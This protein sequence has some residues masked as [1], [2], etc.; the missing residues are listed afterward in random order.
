MKYGFYL[1]AGTGLIILQTSVM[2][3]F[4]VFDGI[5]GM[6]DL[7]IPFILYLSIFC[8]F[9]ES[10]PVIAICGFIMDSFSAGPFGIFSTSYIWIFI[11]IK[12]IAAFIQISGA[13]LSSVLMV[14]GV[15]VENAVVF[16]VF[17]FMAKGDELLPDNALFMLSVQL[18][19][20]ASTGTVIIQTL[21]YFH[22]N[23]DERGWRQSAK[24]LK[25]R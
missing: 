10:L 21:K 11:G 8:P 24:A 16:S 4:F 14:L 1:M 23:Y 15:L 2:P 9:I 22:K 5:Y 12:W 17:G 3:Y 18:V 6:Y 19:C 13:T 20:A 25:Q 7:L